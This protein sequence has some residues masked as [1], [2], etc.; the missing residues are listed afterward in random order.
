MKFG[1]RAQLVHAIFRLHNFRIEQNLGDFNPVPLVE[2]KPGMWRC[3]GAEKLPGHQRTSFN[4]NIYD[5]G[6][7]L[8]R[9]LPPLPA[10]EK[11][12]WNKYER[13]DRMVKALQEAGYRK[14]AQGGRRN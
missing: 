7:N 3:R 8:L 2:F 5:A 11:K 12:Q 10:R 1:D 9:K 13:R 14:P 6:G 4:D